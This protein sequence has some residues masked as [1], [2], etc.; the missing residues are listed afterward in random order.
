M[1]VYSC[2]ATLYFLSQNSLQHCVGWSKTAKQCQ[3][4]SMEFSVLQNS[5]K[6][7]ET[8]VRRGGKPVAEES[9]SAPAGF[10][11]LSH[12]LKA[13]SLERMDLQSELVPNRRIQ[14]DTRIRK[15]AIAEMTSATRSPKE[16]LRRE[17]TILVIKLC[18]L[19]PSSP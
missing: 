14:A 4:V 16:P 17:R 19:H 12:Y 13:V 18:L 2:F 8:V 10:S 15:M 7:K 11:S 3:E 9:L 5:Y 1:S 6:V